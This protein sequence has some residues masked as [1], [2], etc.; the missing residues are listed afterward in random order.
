MRRTTVTNNI[1]LFIQISL[2]YV[3]CVYSLKC[4]V[5]RPGKG[6]MSEKCF[7]HAVGCRIRIEGDAIQWYEYSRLYD[8][9]QLV[10][11]HENEYNLNEIR[12]SGCIRKKSGS[13]RCWCYGQNNCNNPEVSTMLYNGFTQMDE[14]EFEKVIEE[15]DTKDLPDYDSPN[16][17]NNN[18]FKTIRG[19]KN[20]KNDIVHSNTWSYQLKSNEKYPVHHT[21]HPIRGGKSARK[22]GETTNNSEQLSSIINK[23]IKTLKIGKPVKDNLNSHYINIEENDKST[24]NIA[25]KGMRISSKTYNENSQ[26]GNIKIGDY[27]SDSTHNYQRGKGIKLV[28]PKI[29]ETTSILQTEN[30]KSIDELEKKILESPNP[31]VTEDEFSEF[32][33]SNEPVKIP[34][35]ISFHGESIYP[36]IINPTE[37]ESL[38]IK[39]DLDLSL[40]NSSNVIHLLTNILLT[41]SLIIFLL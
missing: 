19:G 30:K 1:F 8:R 39:K 14:Y 9:N 11:V 38:K 32:I 10:C 5:I 3:G 25:S 31:E 7:E 24:N 29:D 37:N 17:E 26:L 16:N 22:D 33:N 13:V 15:V 20:V 6:L 23:D 18:E 4:L 2:I 12:K 34:S 40:K 36:D 41:L 21:A 28:G 27:I 35:E